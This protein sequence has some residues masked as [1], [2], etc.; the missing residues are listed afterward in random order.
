MAQ[1]G[2]Q[3]H[4]R[5]GGTV[6]NV[7]LFSAITD[8]S[9]NA[10]RLKVDGANAYAQ[11]VPQTGGY[12]GTDLMV[13]KS[14]TIHRAASIASPTVTQFSGDPQWTRWATDNTWNAGR[15]TWA[16]YIKMIYFNVPRQMS[17]SLYANFTGYYWSNEGQYGLSYLYVDG[18]L[19]WSSPWMWPS[20][21]YSYTPI[22]GSMTLGPGQ[23]NMGVYM[24]V[25]S[26]YGDESY[27]TC[28]DITLRATLTEQ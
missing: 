24:V 26:S 9:G 12:G 13:R 17:V 15:N 22:N 27:F 28:T 7:P 20:A 11:L 3:L 19:Q 16:E 1:L 2:K 18:T 23:H 21:W 8:T 5:K 14:G 6:T 25:M 10:L 4:Y